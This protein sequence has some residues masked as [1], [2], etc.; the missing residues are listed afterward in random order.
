V[1]S[2]HAQI[3]TVGTSRAEVQTLVKRCER[4]VRT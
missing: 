1:I 2:T 4:S 3:D